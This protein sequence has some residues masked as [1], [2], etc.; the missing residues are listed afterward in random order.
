[1]TGGWCDIIVLNEHAPTEDKGD[2]MKH[3]FYGELECVSDQFLK[4]HMKILLGVLN[5]KAGREN[6]FKPTVVND[7]LHEIS[8]DIGVRVVNFV[9]SKNLI[10]TQEYSVSTLQRS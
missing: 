2:N 10:V 1:V 6:I 5:S 7:R 8:N 4:Y 9:T 3:S